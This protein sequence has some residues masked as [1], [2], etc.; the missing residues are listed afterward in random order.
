MILAFFGATF[1][2]TV[3]PPQALRASILVL[4]VTFCGLALFGV[5]R[6]DGLGAVFY[7]V[8]QL[9]GG[10]FA[11]TLGEFEGGVGLGL[12]VVP[13]DL[14]ASGAVLGFGGEEGPWAARMAPWL[15]VQVRSLRLSVRP[16]LRFSGESDNPLVELGLTVFGT[17]LGADLASTVVE[18][19]FV[20][21]A[22][23]VFF[24]LVTGEGLVGREVAGPTEGGGAVGTVINNA[25]DQR[26]ID[27]VF[28]GRR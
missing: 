21:T 14:F 27:V 3:I 5:V 20:V 2:A 24:A 19:E 7:G 17:E 15:S 4:E 9:F 6:A 13:G 25:G 8:S 1:A 10:D 22:A 12:G 26:A 16:C 11:E 18:E 23:F 28:E